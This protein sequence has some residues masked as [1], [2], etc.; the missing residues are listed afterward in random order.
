MI[1][2]E[3]R[4]KFVTPKAQEKIRSESRLLGKFG[5]KCKSLEQK[6]TVEKTPIERLGDM[7]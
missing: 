2:E 6:T 1:S 5:G 7:T 4:G 3:V